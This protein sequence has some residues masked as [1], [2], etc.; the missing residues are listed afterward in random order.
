MGERATLSPTIRFD[1][2]FDVRCPWCYLGTQRLGRA[3]ELFAQ[4]QPGIAVTATHHSFELAPDIPDRFD[5]SEADYLLRYEG[6]PLEHSARALPALRELAAAE[7]IDLRF[8][9]LR[10]V[11]T[12]RAHRVFQHARA[13]GFG[14]AILER[15]F[16]AYFTECRDLAD[17]DTLAALAAEVG[18]DE[19][20]AREVAD[21]SPEWDARVEADHV[22]GQ[23]LGATG[24]PFSLVNA[25]YRVFGAHPVEVLLQ[26]LRTVCLGAPTAVTGAL[27]TRTDPDKCTSTP[28]DA[29]A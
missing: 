10:E 15:L 25:K 14:E 5:G 6:V 7:G 27:A 8:D 19:S 26:A 3:I 13:E 29:G 17:P 9:N 16:R 28:A 21:S 22:R 20:A 23:M 2:W 4:E 12:R 18:L 24:V 1:V 11:N